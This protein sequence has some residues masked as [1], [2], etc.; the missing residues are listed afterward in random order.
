MP[1]TKPT[2]S[3]TICMSVDYDA[4]STW[5]A[6][7]QTGLRTLSRGEFEVWP[8]RG[9]WGEASPWRRREDH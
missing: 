2:Y 7:G 5:I 4:V 3:T 9:G 8:L 6:A 1:T